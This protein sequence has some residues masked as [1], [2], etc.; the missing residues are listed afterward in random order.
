ME[1][2]KS[3]KTVLL[4]AILSLL[5]VRTGYTQQIYLEAHFDVHAN[6]FA[7]LDDSF[8]NT[9][10]PDDV[11]GVH[12]LSGGYTGG[13]LNVRLG[14][15]GVDSVNVSGGWRRTFFLT[16]ETAVQL[17]FRY[18]LTQ[19]SWFQQEEYSQ[20]LVS[21]DGELY[22][23]GIDSRDGHK[24]VD[25]LSGQKRRGP[26]LST[27]WQEVKVELGLLAAGDH[28][29][30]IG[31]Y[32]KLSSG[33][34][35]AAGISTLLIDDVMAQAS[36]GSGL[37]PTTGIQ[38]AT[39]ASL[40]K[41]GDIPVS[42]YTGTPNI[43]IP[44]HEVNSRSLSIP[45]SMSYHASGIKVEEIAGWVGLGWAL[46]TGGVITRTIRGIPDEFPLGYYHHA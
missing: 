6:G 34:G 36:S 38:S 46:D 25:G 28:A 42:L 27:G 20:V 35:S 4:F 2:K 21:V 16:E 24:F 37:Q 8:L 23:Y 32:S 41:F 29:L 3:I 13:G 14:P 39:A 11:V 18:S 12:T 7:Y 5:A 33:N 19:L 22:G 31:G 15:V 44:L 30:M 43:S 40:G 1:I 9:D 26:H 17:V 10:R 45:L